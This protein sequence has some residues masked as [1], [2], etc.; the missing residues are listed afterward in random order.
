MNNQTTKKK[1]LINRSLVLLFVLLG[2]FA[3]VH[4][5]S[6]ANDSSSKQTYQQQLQSQVD[7]TTGATRHHRPKLR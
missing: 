1:P 7:T 6:A 2:T 4:M 3:A 5:V